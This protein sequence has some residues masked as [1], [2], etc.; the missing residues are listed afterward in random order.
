MDLGLTGKRAVV[1]GAS[2]GI[3]RAVVQALAREGCDVA[4]CARRKEALDETA[5]A[6]AAETGRR[7]FPVPADMS[8][9]ADIEAFVSTGAEL[10]G[11]IDIVVNNAG[12]SIFAE[13]DDVPDERWLSDIELKL[14]GYV[15]T[16]RAALPYLRRQGG[17]IVNVGGNAGRQPLPYHLPG[18]SANAAI[19]NLTVALGQHLARDRIH[20]LTCAMGPVRT[21]RFVKQIAAN[22]RRWGISEEEAEQRFLDELPLGYV[23][24]VEEIAGIIAFLASPRA[25]YMTGTSVTVDGG[26][27]RGI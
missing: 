3:G 11:G 13:F 20:V 24:S 19:L 12:A 10:L 2:E 4:F 1:T 27:T 16:I 26:I 18:G 7:L 23:P 9:R 14:M 15:R 17:R 6:L 8:V 25:A 22:A 21:A 5:R